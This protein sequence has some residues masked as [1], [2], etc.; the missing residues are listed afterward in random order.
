MTDEFTAVTVDVPAGVISCEHC[1]AVTW[2]G[3][4]ACRCEFA[5]LDLHRLEIATCGPDGP[6]RVSHG[7]SMPA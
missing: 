4:V 1:R 6:H 7:S 3:E 5:R 2:A